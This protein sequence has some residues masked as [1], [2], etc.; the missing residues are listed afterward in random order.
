MK[1]KHGKF[2]NYV[3]D[4]K[5][6]FVIPPISPQQKRNGKF[7]SKQCKKC[8]HLNVNHIQYDK[9]DWHY[10]K[11]CLKSKKNSECV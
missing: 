5:G 10:C 2:G 9:T 8:N 6:R 4:Y 3:V 1:V 7:I 11:T